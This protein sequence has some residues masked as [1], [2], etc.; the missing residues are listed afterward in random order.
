[1]YFL[2]TPD[3]GK[4]NITLVKSEEPKTGH[5]RRSFDIKGL[6]HWRLLNVWSS[7]TKTSTRPSSIGTCIMFNRYLAI[8]FPWECHPLIWR[9]L[10]VLMVYFNLQAF[11]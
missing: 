4:Y 7:G 10:S 1:M 2:I 3:T 9:H 11:V 8:E 5:N 6:K